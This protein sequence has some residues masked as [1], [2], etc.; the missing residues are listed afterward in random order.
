MKKIKTILIISMFVLMGLGLTPLI[1]SNEII[2]QTRSIGTLT[3]SKLE[4]ED[5]ETELINEEELNF[6]KDYLSKIFPLE[7]TSGTTFDDIINII[8][9][10]LN[11][12]PTLK[13]KTLV[14]S[15]GWSYNIN[16]F[17]NT[18]LQIKNDLFQFWQY[19]QASKRGKESKTLVIKSNEPIS[20][21][22]IELYSGT[23]IGF[24][25]RPLGIYYFQKNTFPILSSTLFIG[26]ASYVFIT[27]QEEIQIPLIFSST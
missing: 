18:K 4:I 8:K 15:Q 7:K 12:N 10:L 21:K 16:F 14:I 2:E 13:R 23:Q 3:T 24:M 5:A 25:F 17:K 22:T 9:D 6:L 1:S 26:L 20:S 27:A 19:I 11:R